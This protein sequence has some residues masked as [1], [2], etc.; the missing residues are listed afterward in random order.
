[1]SHAALYATLLIAIVLLW[2]A[3]LFSP[4]RPDDFDLAR[5]FE[6]PSSSH[7]LGTADNGADILS[8]LLHGA[9]TTIAIAAG[10]VIL[11]SFV[12]IALG[13]WAGG[14]RRRSI[15][16]V[17]LFLADGF[18]TFPSLILTIA[19]VA[20]VAHPSLMHM[21]FALALPGWVLMMRV[22]R[23][24]VL[25]LREHEYVLAAEVLGFSAMRRWLRH[26]FPS[27]L[28]VTIVQMTLSLGYTILAEATLAF[29]GLGPASMTSGGIASWGT[30][31]E[32]GTQVLLIHPHVVMIAGTVLTC[33][34]FSF[35]FLGEKL[36]EQISF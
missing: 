13:L 10:S 6:M 7:W 27:V 32:Q 21:V 3:P 11:S 18:Q 17:L 8:I 25:S 29:L 33:T 34:V 23:A 30:L 12:G 35:N 14:T 26:I 15:D 28:P 2:A 1:M 9:H 20:W 22:T 19:M 31:L 16:H 4:Y 36:R 24:Q 5:A